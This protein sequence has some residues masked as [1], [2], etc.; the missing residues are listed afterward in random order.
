MKR[1]FALLALA[2]AILT[3]TFTAAAPGHFYFGAGVGRSS[4]NGPSHTSDTVDVLAGFPNGFPLNGQP[5]RAHDTAWSL[6]AGYAATQYIGV[7]AGFWD[8]GEFE[9]TRISGPERPRL[10]IKEAYF[11]ATLRYP[12]FNR[13]ALTGSA[14]ISRASFDVDGSVLVLVVA[15]P[16]GFPVPIGR[17]GV[18][19]PGVIQSV[20]LATPDDE[21]GGYW[22]VGLAVRATDSMEVGLSYGSRDLKVQDVKSTALSVVFAF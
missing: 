10:G 21:T 22:R 19:I 3:P 4:V 17:P 9:S 13:F 15:P 2:L 12:L 1:T 18:I 11:G 20:Q 7:E 5:F 6:L 14:G 8:H 16:P